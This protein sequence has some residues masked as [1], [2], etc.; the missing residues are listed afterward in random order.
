[1][2]YSDSDTITRFSMT[3]EVRALQ[4]IDEI[5]KNIQ[6]ERNL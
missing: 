1:M 6:N 4:L 5:K 3:K 2:L